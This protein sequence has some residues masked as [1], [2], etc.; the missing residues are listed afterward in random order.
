MRPG[1]FLY[2]LWE[3]PPLAV[4]MKVYLFNIT[5]AEEF[6][7]GADK[8]LKVVEIGPYVYQ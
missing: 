6:M 5:N 8:K 4:I 7:S 2:Y 1:S 3:K